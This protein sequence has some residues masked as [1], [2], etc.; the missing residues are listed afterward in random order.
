MSRR[1]DLD[2]ILAT[3][4]ETWHVRL[5]GPYEALLLALDPTAVQAT[6]IHL[7]NANLP[8]PLLADFRTLCRSIEAR[9]ATA[10]P[11]AVCPHCHGVGAH[12]P[13]GAGTT[14]LCDCPAGAQRARSG[15]EPAGGSVRPGK[16]SE[17]QQ[18][19]GLAN[20]PA[21]RRRL[22]WPPRDGRT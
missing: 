21:I 4:W 6:V 7:A 11:P 19:L 18:L 2:E 15:A 16:M 9:D 13:T 3:I 5:T 17:H 22:G 20:V 1:S 12:D 8:W 14:V 10:S